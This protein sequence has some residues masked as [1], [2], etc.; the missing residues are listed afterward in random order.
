M[1]TLYPLAVH[2]LITWPIC[3]HCSE[4][5]ADAVGGRLTLDGEGVSR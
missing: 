1:S 3:K 4:A 5:F 2:A